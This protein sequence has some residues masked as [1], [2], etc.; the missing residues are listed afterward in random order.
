[1]SLG[2]RWQKGLSHQ[3]CVASI[4]AQGE[5]KTTQ[6]RQ[7]VTSAYGL[8]GPGLA[9]EEACAP[10]CSPCLCPIPS[11]GLASFGEGRQLGCSQ[12]S[13]PE[14]RLFL[15]FGSLWLGGAAVFPPGIS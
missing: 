10:L 13:D 3:A 1:M 8:A 14:I 7:P 12:G 11:R 6:G 4:S 9:I 2:G 5:D 15:G